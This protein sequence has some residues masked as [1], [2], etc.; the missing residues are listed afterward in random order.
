M[1]H[2]QC[3]HF[4]HAWD[5]RQLALLAGDRRPALQQVLWLQLRR[6][7][8]RRR[9]SERPSA[10]LRCLPSRWHHHRERRARGPPPPRLPHA[11][12]R[13]PG[14]RHRGRRSLGQP[15]IQGMPLPTPPPQ[16]AIVSSSCLS[17]SCVIALACD[18]VHS[19]WK[20]LPQHPGGPTCA[21][22]PKHRR[23]TRQSWLRGGASLSAERRTQLQCLR[24]H[25]SGACWATHYTRR[26]RL[27]LKSVPEKRRCV[28]RG[29]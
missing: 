24:W 29:S 20:P 27:I 9:R 3:M 5:G 19:S 25:C 7:G 26:Q 6:G 12:R 18:A 22:A 13:P 16:I 8:H 1:R 14:E 11:V 2:I 15:P 23:P 21:G 17:T 4:A 28:R 10:P